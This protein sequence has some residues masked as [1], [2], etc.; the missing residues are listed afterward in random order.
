MANS[1]EVA[2]W[3][4]AHGLLSITWTYCRLIG[5]WLQSIHPEGRVHEKRV[6]WQLKG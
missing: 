5:N 4:V 1:H 2:F 6:K 3:E